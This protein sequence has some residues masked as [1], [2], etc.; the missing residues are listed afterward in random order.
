GRAPPAGPVRPPEGHPLVDGVAATPPPPA[1]P[2]PPP[3]GRQTTPG[4]HGTVESVSDAYVRLSA[5]ANITGVPSLTVPVGHDP[6]GMPIGMQ[7][8]GRPLGEPVLLRVGHA[9]EQS[10]PTRALAPVA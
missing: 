8:L 1:P 2:A 9:Y 5:P 3:R 7:L 10:V 6:A 4:P